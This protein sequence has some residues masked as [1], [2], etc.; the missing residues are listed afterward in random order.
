MSTESILWR[1][2]GRYYDAPGPR[3]AL[4]AANKQPRQNG[5]DIAVWP[6]VLQIENIG[7]KPGSEIHWKIR[8]YYPTALPSFERTIG[9]EIIHLKPHEHFVLDVIDEPSEDTTPG[10]SGMDLSLAHLV[11]TKSSSGTAAPIGSNIFRTS[12]SRADA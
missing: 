7:D 6:R 9:G 4:S 10:H 8:D 1:L 5:H 11:S 12:A 3:L 2:V